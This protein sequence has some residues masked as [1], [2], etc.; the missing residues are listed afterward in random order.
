MALLSRSRLLLSLL[1]VG[2]LLTYPTWARPAV[3]A[4]PPAWAQPA[5]GETPEFHMMTKEMGVYESHVTALR[6]VNAPIKLKKRLIRPQLNATGVDYFGLKFNVLKNITSVHERAVE[7]MLR[8][9]HNPGNGEDRWEHPGFDW[10]DMFPSA[11]GHTIIYHNTTRPHKEAIIKRIQSI[12]DFE[13]LT[14]MRKL[15]AKDDTRWFYQNFDQVEVVPTP[16][17]PFFVPKNTTNTRRSYIRDSVVNLMRSYGEEPI[18][19]SPSDN[20]DYYDELLDMWLHSLDEEITE[21]APWYQV[22]RV[23]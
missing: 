18:K 22:L 20:G 1:L 19:L 11:K 14:W 10:I 13:N 9:L 16:R 5:S 12:A 15:F 2:G 3:P 21:K 23:V 17:G 4:F 7:D 8:K 6:G